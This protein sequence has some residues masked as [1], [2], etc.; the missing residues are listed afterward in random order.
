MPMERRSA[1]DTHGVLTRLRPNLVVGSLVYARVLAAPRDADATLACT[2]VAGKAAGYGPLTGGL[3]FEL[4]TGAA[5]QLLSRPPPPA[6]AA[7]GAALAF[8][9]V[10]GVNGRCWV[11]A[12]EVATCVLVA[13]ALQA[14]AGVD[15]VTACQVVQEL[16]QRRGL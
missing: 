14:T 9:L 11:N 12:A 8:E 2:D 7:L 1:A 4:D 6:L 13:Q 15:G 3:P 16:L 5:R 10:V